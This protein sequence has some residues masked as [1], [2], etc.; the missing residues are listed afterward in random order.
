MAML[1][2][3]RKG[4]VTVFPPSQ[5]PRILQPTKVFDG[6]DVVP[7][8]VFRSRR[9]SPKRYWQGSPHGERSARRNG[10]HVKRQRSRMSALQALSEARWIGHDVVPAPVAPP[11]V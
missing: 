3:D 1:V 4:T 10:R 11:S 6:E 9:Y 8:F 2:N 7:G 5:S